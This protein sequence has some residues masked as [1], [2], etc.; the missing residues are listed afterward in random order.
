VV[1]TVFPQLAV[2]DDEICASFVALAFG[3]DEGS[4]ISAY[5][6]EEAGGQAGEAGGKK[7]SIF[8]E[9]PADGAVACVETHAGSPHQEEPAP[10]KADNGS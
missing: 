8:F 4:M 2:R 10:G 9:V 3:F 7:P 1:G 6:E 5:E